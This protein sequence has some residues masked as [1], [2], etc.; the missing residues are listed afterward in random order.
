MTHFGVL[1]GSREGSQGPQ[2]PPQGVPDPYFEGSRSQI[3][4]QPMMF[5]PKV[6]QKWGQK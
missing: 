4:Y 1:E 3:P 2:D 5:W 6:V